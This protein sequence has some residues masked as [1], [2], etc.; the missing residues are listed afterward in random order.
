MMHLWNV[1]ANQLIS[2][3]E[4]KSA[5]ASRSGTF[6]NERSEIDFSTE[7]AKPSEANFSYLF[8]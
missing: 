6:L 2:Q 5:L 8:N 1:Q 7:S 3:K 4:Q